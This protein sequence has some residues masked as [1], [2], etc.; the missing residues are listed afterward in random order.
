MRAGWLNAHQ[1]AVAGKR[2]G[3]SLWWW[4]SVE[5]RDVEKEEAFTVFR[6]K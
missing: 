3:M 4:A 1:E 6:Q 5:E 2:L